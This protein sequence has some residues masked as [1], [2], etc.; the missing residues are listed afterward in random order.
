MPPHPPRTKSPPV[1]LDD[2]IA[3]RAAM[4]EPVPVEVGAGGGRAGVPPAAASVSAPHCSPHVPST[5]SR[6]EECWRKY[7]VTTKVPN[8]LLPPPSHS[9]G[10]YSAV[11][12]ML[13]LH[14]TCHTLSV[15][16]FRITPPSPQL[17]LDPTGAGR[18]IL[19]T[20]LE[21]RPF[22][23]K[24]FAAPPPPVPALASFLVSL[25]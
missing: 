4:L 5:S 1:G 8:D 17:L 16:F 12:P 24:L 7:A 2:A 6:Q 3:V 25:P 23:T 11:M 22:P 15:P 13:T 21:V 19:T 9:F 10:W 20:I 14:F 18:V